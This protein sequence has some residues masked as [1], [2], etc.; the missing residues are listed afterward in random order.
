MDNTYPQEYILKRLRANMHKDR[1]GILLVIHS[2]YITIRQMDYSWKGRDTKSWLTYYHNWNHLPKRVLEL[3]QMDALISK[4]GGDAHLFD[5][6]FDLYC[7][8]I[9]DSRNK[10]HQKAEQGEVR[11]KD[12]D[13]VVE[14]S[15][16]P[17]EDAEMH[18][19]DGNSGEVDSPAETQSDEDRK[20]DEQNQSGSDPA[21]ST[22]EEVSEE[23][24]DAAIASLDDKKDTTS[25]GNQAQHGGVNAEIRSYRDLRNAEKRKEVQRLVKEIIRLCKQEAGTD[26]DESPRLNGKKLV[27]E[28]V[29]KRYSLNRCRKEEVSKMPVLLM[30]DVSG[31]CSASAGGNL[32]ACLIAQELEPELIQ[33]VT[34]SNGFPE[35]AQ[36]EF[37]EAIYTGK[38]QKSYDDPV[39]HVEYYTQ[40]EWSLVINFGDADA[41]LELEAMAEK[42]ANILVLDSFRAKAGQAHLSDREL[43]FPVV[44]VDGVNTATAAWVG[45]KIY[46][47]ERRK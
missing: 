7:D 41:M 6:L 3:A 25:K 30:V 5:I 22:S 24:I 43:S 15:D 9:V 44:W 32:E 27:T 18:G 42:G 36:G 2:D 21:E 20:G 47:E 12:T 1:F 34:H 17:S 33:V 10:C 29:T 38:R 35:Q 37:L 26:G 23:D 28:L 46:K 4:Y 14:A 8:K 31:S 45:L 13:E 39:Y 16:D 11:K 19:G 40:Q